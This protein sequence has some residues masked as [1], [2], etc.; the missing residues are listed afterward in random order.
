MV[1]R[2]H[3]VKRYTP[4]I[5]AGGQVT[6]YQARNGSAVKF[7][8]YRSLASDYA[9]L[10]ARAQELEEALRRICWFDSSDNDP[11]AVAAIVA[12]RSALQQ[13]REP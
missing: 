3:L 8:D 12:G 4:A 5:G 11:D 6:L 10:E 2:S 13:G 1:E 9:T 7:A